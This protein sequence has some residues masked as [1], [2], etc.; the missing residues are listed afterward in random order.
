MDFRL[1]CTIVVTGLLLC[2]AFRCSMNV[3]LH[4]VSYLTASTQALTCLFSTAFADLVNFS[5]TVFF[6]TSLI[7]LICLPA[8]DDFLVRLIICTAATLREAV[9]L[10]TLVK[11]F[12]V[13]TFSTSSGVH[14]S[15]FSHNAYA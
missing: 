3:L 15:S 5:T 11:F 4:K 9:N 7:A 14:P 13:G 8:T 6:S 10:S 2:I 12:L 1:Q